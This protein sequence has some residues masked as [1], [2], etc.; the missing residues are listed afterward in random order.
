MEN[1]LKLLSAVRINFV[2]GSIKGHITVQSKNNTIFLTI[3]LPYSRTVA[4]NEHVIS[5][6]GFRIFNLVLIF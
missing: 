6:F 1:E 4:G 5:T 2:P 3:L